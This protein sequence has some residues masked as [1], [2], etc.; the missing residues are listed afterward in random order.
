MSDESPIIL[1]V[2]SEY[3]INQRLDIWLSQKMLDLSR[4]HIQK[5]ISQGHVKVNN[6]LCTSKKATVQ[7]GDKI[8]VTIPQPTLLA[9]KANDIPLDLSLIHI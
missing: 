4:S 1:E 6:N 3:E 5:L 9:I 8:I 2:N 7:K